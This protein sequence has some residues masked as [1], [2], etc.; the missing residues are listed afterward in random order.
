MQNLDYGKKMNPLHK[1]MSKKT[2]N[3]FKKFNVERFGSAY[4]DYSEDNSIDL[5]L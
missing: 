4:S 5:S 2:F 3:L 1:L